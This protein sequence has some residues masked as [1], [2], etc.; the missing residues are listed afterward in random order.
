MKHT[1]S[2]KTGHLLSG[3]LRV[4]GY[5][6]EFSLANI[7]FKRTRKD[8]YVYEMRKWTEGRIYFDVPP[9]KRI[10]WQRCLC[11]R[12]ATTCPEGSLEVG[13]SAAALVLEPTGNINGDIKEY[14]RVGL[15]EWQSQIWWQG[16]NTKT[17]D[18]V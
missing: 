11:L 12:I 16:S 8:P 10:N 15:L 7:G 3:T 9:K 4:N 1:N 17:I 6:G 18:L 2:D 5:F 13:A 14:R